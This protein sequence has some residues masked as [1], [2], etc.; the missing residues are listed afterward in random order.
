MF[1]RLYKRKQTDV[2]VYTIILRE[3]GEEFVSQYAWFLLKISIV[4]FYSGYKS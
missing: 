4:S 3:T 2:R 1:G